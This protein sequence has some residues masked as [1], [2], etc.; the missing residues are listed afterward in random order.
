MRPILLPNGVIRVFAAMTAPMEQLVP[1]PQP[2][3]A[4]AARSGMATY[5]GDSSKAETELGWTAR[6]VREGMLET[7]RAELT[8]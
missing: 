6:P 3:T 4:E 8:A 1:V 2:L 5:L 7:V